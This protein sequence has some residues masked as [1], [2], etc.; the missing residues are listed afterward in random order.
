MFRW[1]WRSRTWVLVV[2]F[3]VTMSPA[4]IAQVICETST[5]CPVGTTPAVMTVA[6]TNVSDNGF[7]IKQTH[8]AAQTF[9]VPTDT[10]FKLNAVIFNAR[11]NNSPGDRE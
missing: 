9:K 3:V 2:I 5:T 4:L 10:C 7:Q 8:I 11:K 6:D 1:N